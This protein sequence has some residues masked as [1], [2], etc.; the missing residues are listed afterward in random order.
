M[1]RVLSLMWRSDPCSPE[2]TPTG[3]W[4][5]TLY[6]DDDKH[7]RSDRPISPD[8]DCTTCTRYAVGYLRHL[9][10]LR[11]LRK[12]GE[13]LY[14]RLATIHNLRFMTQLMSLLRTGT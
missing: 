10:H 4:H 8:C 13:T 11:H 7:M 2:F 1:G 12:C 5:D 6:I 3:D 9:R 14:F